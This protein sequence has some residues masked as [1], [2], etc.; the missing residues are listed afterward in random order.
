MDYRQLLRPAPFLLIFLFAAV[1]VGDLVQKL[2]EEPPPPP[3]IAGIAIPRFEALEPVIDFR[4]EGGDPA[5]EILPIPE[6]GQGQWSA[7]KPQ[8]VWTRGAVA[9]LRLEFAAGGHRHLIM[10]CLP[11][12]G[13]RPVGSLRMTLNGLELG[14]I[15]LVPGWH[16]YRIALPEGAVH[17][18]PNRVVLHF[19]DRGP[20]ERLRRALL[21]RKLGWF[22]DDNVDVE[23]L[24]DVRPVFLDLDAERVNILRS[25]TLEIPVV[26]DDRT[27]ALQMRYRFSTGSGRAD[28]VVEQSEDGGV[29]LDDGMRATMSAQEKSRG[30]IRIPLHGRRG[31]FVIRIRA[32]LE[33]PGSQL[34][35]SS[36]R[37]VEEGDPT[38]RPW[39]AIRPPN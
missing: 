35:I 33:T 3:E 1:A 18:G 20:A 32:Y 10:E 22:L 14:V 26:L 2:T 36:L 25:G 15:D 7:P 13:K 17:P 19:P 6:L 39:A 21:I 30:R 8:G 23:I 11:T 28:V 29:G 4:L 27:D 37:L 31:S 12:S 24:D 34:V 38:R 5:V 9:D 16:R